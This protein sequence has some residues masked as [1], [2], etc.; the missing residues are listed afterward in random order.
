MNK[1]SRL[2]SRTEEFTNPVKPKNFMFENT[3]LVLNTWDK[4]FDLKVL[5]AMECS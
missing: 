1:K 4:L 2:A 3:L 5:D